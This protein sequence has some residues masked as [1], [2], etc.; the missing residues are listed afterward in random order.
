MPGSH[1]RLPDTR[2][3]DTSANLLSLFEAHRAAPIRDASTRV[4][5][6][7]GGLAWTKLPG[8]NYNPPPEAHRL[9]TSITVLAELPRGASRRR[10]SG[11]KS[12]VAPKPFLWQNRQNRPMKKR[13]PEL[14]VA[15]VLIA[16]VSLGTRQYWAEKHQAASMAEAVIASGGQPVP[17]N[18][19]PSAGDQ[20]LVQARLQLE[21]RVSVTARLRYQ[22]SLSGHTL[23]GF[24][25]YWQ[26]GR[27]E[28]MHMRFEL[29]V[30]HEDTS[31]LQ[32]SNGRFI[33]TDQQV[34]AGR[35]ITRL[36]LR[37]VRRETN[38]QADEMEDLLTGGIRPTPPPA[39]LS[40]RTG[41]LPTLLQVLGDCFTFLP[42]Q[43]MRW[44]PAQPLEGLP[45][46]LPVFAVVGHWK[47]EVLALFVPEGKGLEALPERLPQEVLLLFGQSDLFP[48]RIEFRRLLAPRTASAASQLAAFTLSSDPLMLLELSAVS[49]DS[50]VPA[51]QFDY[52][53]GDAHWI[54]QTSE[55]I[56]ALKRQRAERMAIQKRALQR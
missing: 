6:R 14:T 50:Q 30:N 32:V 2:T 48:Y 29:R 3:G 1:T 37:K 41:G 56:D 5:R 18:S 26:Q 31:L 49:F 38:Q 33:W 55:Y 53:A 51:G 36:D 25:G 43:P 10:V 9:R 34:P 17:A 12:S 23:A 16:A 8:G 52:S 45:E 47:P 15:T 20:L 19:Q 39:E 46:S 40:L 42:P 27:G 35:T 28:D 4:Y 54:D 11:I 44:T 13:L 24:G 22:A 7:T 21:R